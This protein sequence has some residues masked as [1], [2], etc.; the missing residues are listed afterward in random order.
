MPELQLV[1]IVPVL[2]EY[3]MMLKHNG[4]AP[5]PGKKGV[6]FSEA[7]A[8]HSKNQREAQAFMRFLCF[9]HDIPMGLVK[10][11]ISRFLENMKVRMEPPAPVEHK[12]SRWDYV[13]EYKYDKDELWGKLLQP[14]SE[15]QHRKTGNLLWGLLQKFQAAKVACFMNYLSY[16]SPSLPLLPTVVRHASKCWRIKRMAAFLNKL[17][18]KRYCTVRERILILYISLTFV[19]HLHRDLDVLINMIPDGPDGDMRLRYEVLLECTEWEPYQAANNVWPRIDLATTYYVI[20]TCLDIARWPDESAAKFAAMY[21][22]N[23]H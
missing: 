23:T 18:N 14:G 10:G 22:Y 15:S 1:A 5:P 2:V 16:A 21:V 9:L 7:L 4:N 20:N 8:R 13:P 3:K 17:I 11:P 19:F 6:I 12:T